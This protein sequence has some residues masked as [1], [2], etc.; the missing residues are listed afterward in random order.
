[1]GDTKAASSRLLQTLYCEP[2]LRFQCLVKVIP[3]FACSI[4]EIESTSAHPE[5][6]QAALAKISARLS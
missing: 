5:L 1:M 4:F 3:T 6:H 2:S